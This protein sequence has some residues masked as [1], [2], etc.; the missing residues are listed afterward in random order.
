MNKMVEL[1]AAPSPVAPKCLRLYLWAGAGRD[2]SSGLDLV[3][4]AF[5]A[6]CAAFTAGGYAFGDP[7]H[8]LHPSGH[9]TGSSQSSRRALI[10]RRRCRDRSCCCSRAVAGW[11]GYM[12]GMGVRMVTRHFSEKLRSVSNNYLL[13]YKHGTHRT[14][15]CSRRL[16]SPVRIVVGARL[17]ERRVARDARACACAP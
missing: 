9:R 4:S 8:F 11:N 12:A 17:A 10:A 5:K 13:R 6:G 14:A 1:D 16:L 15:V 3:K 7:N 2:A